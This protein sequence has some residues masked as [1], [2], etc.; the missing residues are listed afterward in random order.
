MASTLLPPIERLLPIALLPPIEMLPTGL[1]AC[2]LLATVP[3][4]K[5]PTDKLPTDYVLWLPPKLHTLPIQLLHLGM[6]ANGRF[7]TQL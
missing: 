1:P 7:A 6:L 5:V 2:P 4:D 3:T